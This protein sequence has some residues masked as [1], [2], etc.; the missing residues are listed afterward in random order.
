MESKNNDYPWKLKYFIAPCPLCS[1]LVINRLNML[2]PYLYYKLS[3]WN[4]DDWSV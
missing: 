3:F 2:F 4:N 1:K